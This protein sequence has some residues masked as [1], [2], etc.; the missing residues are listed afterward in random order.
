MREI[1]ENWTS[2]TAKKKLL[3]K[4]QNTQTLN[5]QKSGQR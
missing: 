5:W 4:A 1:D 3:K 2:R